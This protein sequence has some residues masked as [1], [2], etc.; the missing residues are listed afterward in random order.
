V[1]SGA[2]IIIFFLKSRRDEMRTMKTLIVVFVFAALALSGLHAQEAYIRDCVG[3]VEVRAPGAAAWTPAKIGQ[4]IS[5]STWIST[6]FRSTAVIVLGNSSLVVR[7]VT[8]LSLEELRKMQGTD[9]I[10]VYLQTGRV[11]A[12][13]RP[14]AGGKTS[15]TVRSP[16]ATAS[17]RG[18]SFDFDGVNLRVDQGLV[19][20]TGGDTSSVYVG[21]GHQAVSNPETGRTAGPA[22]MVRAELTPPVAGPVTESMADSSAQNAVAENDSVLGIAWE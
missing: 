1:E 14:P 10:K 5:E 9:E 22:E 20:V 13:V 15:F 6:G 7:P 19:H 8:R 11:R 21:A 4:S 17:V 2:G 18:T 16:I 3:T 12:E